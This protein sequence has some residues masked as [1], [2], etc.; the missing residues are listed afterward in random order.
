MALART[1]SVAFEGV[2]ARIVD[3]EANVGPGL[4]GTYIVG[5]ADKAVAESRDR[6]KLAAQNSHLPWPKT[7]I[8][9][10]LSPAS[11][12]K[13][14]SHFDLPMVLSILFAGASGP[15][16]DHILSTTVFLGEVSL[17]GG[18]KPVTGIIPAILAA[19]NAGYVRVVIPAGNA[20]EATLC[21]DMDIRVA[22]ALTDVVRFV[23]GESDLEDAHGSASDVGEDNPTVLDMRDVAGQP[24]ARRAAEIAAA[25]GHNFLMIGPPGSGKSMIAARLPGL[26]PD[27]TPEYKLEAT[28]VHSVAGRTFTGPVIHPPF[29]APHHS[30]TRAALI[31]GGAGNPVPGAVSLAHRGVLF[32]DE[33]SE[34]SA[35]ILDSLRTPLE[36]GYVRLIRSRRDVYF[37]AKFQLV[38]A[39]NPCRCGAEEPSACRCSANARARY[40]NNVSGPL[41]D[42]LDMVVRTH[43][44]G[45]VIRS[46]EQ[47][48]TAVIRQRVIEA[49]GRAG[50]RWARASYPGVINAEIDGAWLRREFP[51][52]EE[53][54]EYLAVYLARGDISQRGV[55][56]T[57][58]LAWTIADL[59]G[60]DRPDID[61]VAQALEF[62]DYA[63]G[64]VAA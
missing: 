61:H 32:L 16:E 44:Q 25:G 3:V 18:I 47:E 41:R 58:K 53:A 52:D 59:A 57:L 64:E 56:R 50:H 46:E 28:A 7:K 35:S 15:Y 8:I 40:L 5:L 22:T 14:G 31:G 45:S 19:K 30:V 36:Q 17:D 27:L 49:R 48:S 20:A 6:I 1:K 62:H 33:V 12:R 34:I 26:L 29:V 54:M 9:V 4:P 21:Q 11:L 63:G 37:P 2:T 43:A 38:M 51:A 24:E 60:C 39:A 23:A 10:S 13:S 55:D 42:R